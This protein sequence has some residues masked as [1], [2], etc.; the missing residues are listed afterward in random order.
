MIKYNEKF[1]IEFDLIDLQ[2]H[3]LSKKLKNNSCSQCYSFMIFVIIKTG[4]HTRWRK[5]INCDSTSPINRVY[6]ESVIGV[7]KN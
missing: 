7:R 3:P 2:L 5:I 1:N 6:V 4:K